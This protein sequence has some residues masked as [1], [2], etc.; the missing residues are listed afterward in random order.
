MQRIDDLYETAFH[1]AG[2][3]VVGFLLGVDFQEV[4]IT[5]IPDG[6]FSAC[7][8]F[9]QNIQP[10]DDLCAAFAGLLAQAFTAR[11]EG[12]ASR[13][14][15]DSI[16]DIRAALRA[17][18][19][20]YGGKRKRIGR[21]FLVSCLPPADRVKFKSYVNFRD[22]FFAALEQSH[23][24]EPKNVKGDRVIFHKLHSAAHKARTLLAE[25]M[26]LLRALGNQLLD[27]K[28]MSRDELKAFLTEQSARSGE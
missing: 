20:M 9:A 19:W 1:E 11:T 12:V 2:H 17:L 15:A 26:H 24:P 14:A 3:A 21:A 18:V 28:K 10:Q 7:V 22:Q 6:E 8:A 13:L 25:N 23:L 16:L 5:L 4:A 27:V